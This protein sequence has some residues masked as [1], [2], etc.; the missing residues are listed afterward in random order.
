MARANNAFLSGDDIVVANEQEIQSEIRVYHRDPNHYE[1][2][3][4]HDLDR[5]QMR[6][7]DQLDM[8]LSGIRDQALANI[9]N[10]ER[11]NECLKHLQDIHAYFD[12]M[13]EAID[14]VEVAHDQPKRSNDPTPE[15]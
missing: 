3:Q 11:R 1:V 12:S 14:P 7:H 6:F 10:E 4:T 8:L 15:A 9:N 13:N 2:F 5:E